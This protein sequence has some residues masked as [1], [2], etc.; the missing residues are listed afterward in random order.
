M[1]INEYRL[2]PSL[3]EARAQLPKCLIKRRNTW[4][5]RKA[6]A[7]AASLQSFFQDSELLNVAVREGDQ[8]VPS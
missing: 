7:T 8:I 4:D 6:A 2:D 1:T 5:R 3:S